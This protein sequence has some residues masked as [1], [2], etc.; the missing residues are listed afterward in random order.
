MLELF[1]ERRRCYD[2]RR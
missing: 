2:G 1:D